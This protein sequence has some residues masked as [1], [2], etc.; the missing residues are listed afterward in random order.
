M[1]ISD[2]KE[3][4]KSIRQIRQQKLEWI[5]QNVDVDRYDPS[6]PSQMDDLVRLM[7]AN[8]VMKKNSNGTMNIVSTEKLIIEAKKIKKLGKGHQTI[9]A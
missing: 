6:N 3:W 8:G 2:S 9:I 1:A 5:L 4:R 7:R